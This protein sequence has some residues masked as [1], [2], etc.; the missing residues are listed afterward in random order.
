MKDYSE[1]LS[2]YGVTVNSVKFPPQVPRLYREREK[3]VKTTNKK[4]MRKIR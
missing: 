1:G 2:M 3:G 4:K